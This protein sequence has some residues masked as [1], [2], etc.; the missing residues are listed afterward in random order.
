[1]RSFFQKAA[2]AVAFALGVLSADAFAQSDD[3]PMQRLAAVQPAPITTTND[4]LLGAGD[5]VHV[6]VYGEDDLTGEYAVDGNGFI[7]LPLVGQVKAAGYSGPALQVA[8]AAAFSNGYLNN[9][10]VS[11][12][13]TTYRPFYII[14]QVNKPGEY[15]YV[16]GM[17]ALNAVALAGGYTPQASDAY[18]YVRKIGETAETKLPADQTT[19]IHPGDVVR[20]DQTGFWAVMTVLSPLAGAAE[21][22]RYAAP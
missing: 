6:T 15:P 4:Y 1:M 11:V 20:V 16:N 18:V 2:V 10:R 17:T 14:G 8:I 9:P 5:K 12:E 3:A 19:Q 13:I 21:A 7:A 22:A